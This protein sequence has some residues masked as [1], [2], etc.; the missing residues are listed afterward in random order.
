MTLQELINECQNRT[1]HNSSDF[2][3]SWISFINEAVR[4]Y[5]RKHPWA[6]L[7]D[8]Y[9]EVLASGQRF[10]VFPHYVEDV[11]TIL[12]TSNHR[13]I[14]RDGEF[15]RQSPAVFSQLTSGRPVSYDLIGDVAATAEPS[16]YCYVASSNA[17]D[18][19]AVRVQGVVAQS[20]ASGSAIGTTI[21][22]ETVTLS[23]TSPV[24][25]A[26]Q[27]TRFLAISKASVTSGDVTLFDAGN[28]N[29]HISFMA[30]YETR[31]RFRRAQFL[32]V[33][34]ARTD[35]RVRFRYRLPRLV[36]DDDSLLPGV[37]PDFV[38][39]QALAIYQREEEQYQKGAF[40]E[41]KA[42]STLQ[43][44]AHKEQNYGEPFSQ[45]QPQVPFE[46]DASA[47]EFSRGW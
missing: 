38:I 4:D 36:N 13:H 8:E 14:D 25:L 11:L 10:L 18:V 42:N 34:S 33:P 39:N 30:D 12:D 5:A 15:S 3:Q 2:T 35:L 32:F 22:T 41:A 17:S 47:D 40:H 28:S 43:S 16:G 37:D 9:S 31:A 29:K 44:Q 24:T 46:N 20:G 45:I 27:F 19:A 23:G 26:N 21:K 1:S 6:G 7:E